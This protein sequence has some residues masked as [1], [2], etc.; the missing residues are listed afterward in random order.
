[1]Q[2]QLTRLQ[3]ELKGWQRQLQDM[4]QQQAELTTQYQALSWSVALA[5]VAQLQFQQQALPALTALQQQLAQQLAQCQQQLQQYQQQQQALLEAQQQQQ[6]RQNQLQQLTQ[7]LALVRSSS[8]SKAKKNNNNCS[9]N[10]NS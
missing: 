7:E 1:M 3:T 10:N 6:Q 2:Q 9:S 4:A 8:I 5:E